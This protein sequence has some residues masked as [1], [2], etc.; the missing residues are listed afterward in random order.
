MHFKTIT[1]LTLDLFLFIFHL[2]I[3][4]PTLEVIA[5]KISISTHP[6]DDFWHV[7]KHVEPKAP[8]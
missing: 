2:P 5:R 3:I 6:L 7:K 8:N 4:V 1:Y